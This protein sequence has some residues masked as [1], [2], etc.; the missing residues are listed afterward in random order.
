MRLSKIVLALSLATGFA[1]AATTTAPATEKVAKPVKVVT[2]TV[3]GT[4]EA[5]D[6]IANTLIVKAGK[7]ID[8]VAVTAETKVTN[9]GKDAVIGDLKSGDNVTVVAK[10]EEGK[11]VATTVKVGAAKKAPAKK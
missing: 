11:L 8:T 4:V 2:V 9:A 1:F 7:K 5:V 10:K 6:A 3:K